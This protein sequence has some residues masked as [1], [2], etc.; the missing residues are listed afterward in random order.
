MSLTP[1]TKLKGPVSI[2]KGPFASGKH[3][4]DY[5]GQHTQRVEP[6]KPFQLNFPE[7]RHC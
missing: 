7:G 1:C 5:P 3:Q 2:H 4:L 6:C